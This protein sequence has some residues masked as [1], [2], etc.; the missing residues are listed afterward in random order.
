MRNHLHLVMEPRDAQALSIAMQG[1]AIRLAKGLNRIWRRK[2]R[3]F[4]SRYHARALTTPLEV[5]RALAYVL[6]NARRHG[7]QAGYTY[8]PQWLD[9]FSSC[10]VFEGWKN[11]PPPSAEAELLTPRASPKTWLRKHGW[12]RHGRLVR[13]EI[14]RAWP[15]SRPQG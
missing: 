13:A 10:A 15:K 1:F 14:P 5:R 7:A 9:P 8:P 11:R 2:G 3:V 4:A 12:R 6:N